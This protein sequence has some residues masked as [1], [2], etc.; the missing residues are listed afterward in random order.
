MGHLNNILTNVTGPNVLNRN[1]RIVTGKKKKKETMSSAKQLWPM[2]DRSKKQSLKSDRPTA[3]P[4]KVIYNRMGP[5]FPE[6]P[7]LAPPPANDT[8]YSLCSK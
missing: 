2:L 3:L 5:V 4:P 6:V 7:V 8:E 1:A